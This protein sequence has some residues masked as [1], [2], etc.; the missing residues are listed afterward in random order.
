[1]S[2]LYLAYFQHCPKG[3]SNFLLQI[4]FSSSA[5]NM[6]NPSSSSS[7]SSTSDSSSSS[8]S[9]SD[10]ERS[11]I[12]SFSFSK[13]QSTSLAKWVVT[14]IGSQRVKDA[15]ES[16]KPKLKSKEGILTNPT[17]DEDL[18][19]KLKAVKRSNA[20]KANID[21]LEKEFHKFFFR[22]LDLA[23]PLIYLS[24]RQKIK[25]KSKKDVLV[26]RTALKLWTSLY[27][28]ILATRRRNIMTQV[29]PNFMSL[30]E[31][32][33]LFKGGD[34]LFGPAF[35]NKLVGHAMAQSTLQQIPPSSSDSRASRR[36]DDNCQQDCNAIPRGNNGNNFGYETVSLAFH[37]SFGGRVARFVESWSIITKDPWIQQTVSRGFRLDFVSEPVQYFIPRNTPMTDTQSDL[38]DGEVRSLLDKGAVVR[39][40]GEEFLS[41]IF[42]IPKKSGGFRPIINLKGLNSFIKY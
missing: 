2:T 30:L 7:D 38:C 12:V 13:A 21:P 31:D 19:T 17:L 35:L 1:M 26:I 11:R 10:D 32:H 9:S 37:N 6:S 24:S 41:G 15:R 25:R 39:V 40:H 23:K 20:S 29:Y 42:L 8:S 34:L 18:Y 5:V 14:G 4:F 36:A 22:V 27:H 16:F 28:D 3:G 33:Q